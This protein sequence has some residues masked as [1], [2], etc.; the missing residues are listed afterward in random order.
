MA[1]KRLAKDV[2]HGGLGRLGGIHQ[3]G[4]V[5]K[6]KAIGHPAHVATQRIGNVASQVSAGS[7]QREA[8]SAAFGEYPEAR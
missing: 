6:E 5:S 3:I 8:P 7:S 2:L 4:V 1:E